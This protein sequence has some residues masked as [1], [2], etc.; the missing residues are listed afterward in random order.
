MADVQRE[1]EKETERWRMREMR[2]KQRDGGCTE[3]R[4]ERNREMADV[5]RE[6]ERGTER[7]RMYREKIR[8]KQRDGGCT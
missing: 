8:K 4:S 6:D 7:W 2:K 1:D 5:Q 3:R